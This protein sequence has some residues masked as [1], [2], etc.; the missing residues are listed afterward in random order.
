MKFPTVTAAITTTIIGLFLAFGA[1][2]EN[3]IWQNNAAYSWQLISAHFVHIGADHL[4]WNLLALIIL[5][6]IIEQHSV[7]RLLLS[8][9]LGC[10]FVNLYL[11][12]LFDLPAYAGLSGV[13]NTL[14][15][16]ALYQIAQ[17]P[18]YRTA[19][20]VSF[21]ASIAKISLEWLREDALFS[22]L[23]WP[24]VPQAHFAG[25]LGGIVLCLFI[26]NDCG[27]NANKKA[28]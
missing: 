4:T 3:L 14:L 8:L 10:A 6:S 23:I 27:F 18:E 22:S 2:P 28:A 9:T 16:V 1:L 15:V 26:N 21:M 12:T 5:A 19:A 20:I 13:L 17:R 7:K 24:S 11:L 25:L